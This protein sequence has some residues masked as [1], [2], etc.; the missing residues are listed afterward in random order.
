V[1]LYKK[2]R[3]FWE[4]PDPTL[5]PPSATDPY[6]MLVGDP[7][8]RTDNHMVRG[9]R[10]PK[11]ADLYPVKMAVPARYTEAMVLLQLRDACGQRTMLHWEVELI[12][13][14]D[15][16]Q[17][18]GLNLD[19]QDLRPAFRDY[20]VA[21]NADDSDTGHRLFCRLFLELKREKRIPPPERPWEAGMGREWSQVLQEYN[22]PFKQ[23]DLE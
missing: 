6:Y 13:L 19:L 21:D 8:I 23:S 20:L 18:L 4:F 5:G 1:H 11:P 15:P 22:I 16:G 12:Y 2:S 3:L 10:G 7:R 14:L 9:G 17:I